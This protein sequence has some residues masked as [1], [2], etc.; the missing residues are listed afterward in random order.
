MWRARSRIRSRSELQ[1]E[2]PVRDPGDV[3]FLGR[4]VL[5]ILVAELELERAPRRRLESQAGNTLDHVDL[6][7]ICAIGGE[8]RIFVGAVDDIDLAVRREPRRGCIADEREPG[9]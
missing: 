5:V 9:E 8:E 6:R 1:A 4:I 3:A 7:R 2:R